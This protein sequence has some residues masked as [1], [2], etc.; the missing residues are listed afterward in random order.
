M[1]NKKKF[2][3]TIDNEEDN[4]WNPESEETTENA[5]F[6]IRFQELCNRF[7][8]KPVYLTT[9]HMARDPVFADF[10]KT[11]LQKNQCEIGMHL[12]AWSTP[13]EYDL[14]KT[15]NERSYLIEYPLDIMEEKIC[16]LHNTLTST[17][18][19]MVS[20]RSGRWALNQEYLAL[21]IKY[22]YRCDCSVTPGV[23]WGAKLG[24]TG[25]PGSDYSRE[26][27]G[28]YEIMDGMLEVPVSIHKIRYFD[29]GDIK[30]PKAF[31]K[32]I[33]HL[34]RGKST[35][36]RPSFTSV[37]RMEKLLDYVKGT[38]SDY[39]MFM[40]HSSELM[41]GG[42]PYYKDELAIEQLYEQMEQLFAYASRDF[43]GI[44]LRDYVDK[45]QRKLFN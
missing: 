4:Q 20:H 15:S 40:L 39:I 12:H 34:L 22:G 16:T 35:W 13:P 30:T 25:I 24:A 32:E 1:S 6:L 14:Q 2:I 9:Y 37:Y 10:A 38:N 5:K 27:N 44:T 17:F 7:D 21:L 28:A 31:A 45:K 19:E 36:M 8:F 11:A 29:V 23:N 18:G 43:E 26:Q 3:I 41:P 33:S 42:S